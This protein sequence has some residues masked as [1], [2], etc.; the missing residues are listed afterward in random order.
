M[1]VGSSIQNAANSHNYFCN[2]DNFS[3]SFPVSIRE[4]HDLF[5]FI[6][7]AQNGQIPQS[8]PKQ[9]K[10]EI[11]KKL[12]N[13]K[14]V[15]SI[16]CNRQGKLTITTKN[17]KTAQEILKLDSILNTPVTAFIQT[18]TITSRFLLRIDC[19]ISCADIASEL[20]EQGLAIHEVRRFIRNSCGV[21]QPT[22]SVLVTSY[23]T[24]LPTDVKLWMQR[25][26]IQLFHDRPRQCG[27]CFRFNHSTKSCRSEQICK[28]CSQVHTGDCS[29]PTLLCT[30]CKENHAADD[31]NCAAY[32]T[33]KNL[34]KFRSEHH[35]TLREARRQ[36]QTQRSSQKPLYA[37]VA[38]RA[39]DDSIKQSQLDSAIQ[40]I[41]THFTNLVQNM[42]SEMQKSM[43]AM[44]ESIATPLMGLIQELQTKKIVSS[45]LEH[46]PGSVDA[47]NKK[48]KHQTSALRDVPSPMDTQHSSIIPPPQG[49]PVGLSQ[50]LGAG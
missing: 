39:P 21:P 5:S 46:L 26:P 27:K 15:E 2:L 50:S 44:V 25:Y 19:S 31:K 8:H 43:Q 32:I 6:I 36:F 7:S 42:V 3:S 10:E 13:H 34:Q 38:A 45:K 11:A 23:G 20:E 35:L 18:E 22:P 4:G 41:T 47:P 24:S 40:Q 16:H 49:D 33:E 14:L 9:L 17:A 1:A 28:K 29:T 48:F 30:N 37:A 12:S